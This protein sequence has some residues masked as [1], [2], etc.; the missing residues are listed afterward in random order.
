MSRLLK[1][2]RELRLET[3]E[4]FDAPNR[5]TLYH[6]RNGLDEITR[7]NHWTRPGHFG[8]DFGYLSNEVCDIL[9]GNVPVQR[10]VHHAMLDS[11]QTAIDYESITDFYNHIIDLLLSTGIVFSGAITET[12]RNWLLLFEEVVP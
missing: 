11:Q 1:L 8:G 12:V 9:N 2:P 6:K 10:A 3:Y 7:F 5:V 4:Y